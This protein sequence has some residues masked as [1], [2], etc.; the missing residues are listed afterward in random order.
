MKLHH[1]VRLRD[2]DG[3]KAELDCERHH[4]VL[5]KALPCRVE[6][7]HQSRLT[8]G[9]VAHLCIAECERESERGGWRTKRGVGED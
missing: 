5:R 9:W 1:A 2:G 8:D 7:L 3:L 6:H 4:V